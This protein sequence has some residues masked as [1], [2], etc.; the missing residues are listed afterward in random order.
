MKSVSPPDPFLIEKAFSFFIACRKNEK[1]NDCG[2]KAAPLHL[3]RYF[4][5][6]FCG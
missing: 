2:L 6:P 1:M 5:G 4:K 3:G